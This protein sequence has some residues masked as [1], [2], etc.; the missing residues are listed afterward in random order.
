MPYITVDGHYADIILQIFGCSR[1]FIIYILLAF[2]IHCRY[3]WLMDARTWW[4]GLDETQ[5]DTIGQLK[6]SS[7]FQYLRLALD[8][9][10]T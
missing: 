3:L 4:S 2:Y 10:K 1:Y 9:T 8:S 7:L 5:N 6:E